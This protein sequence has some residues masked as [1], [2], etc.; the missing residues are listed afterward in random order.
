MLPV[1]T[2]SGS[3]DVAGGVRPLDHVENIP[4]IDVVATRSGDS[5]MLTLLCVNRSL[6]SDIKTNFDLGQRRVAAPVHV[7]QIS[8]ASRYERNDEVEPEHI[9]PVPGTISIPKAGA[10]SI[11]LPHESVTVLRVK[12]R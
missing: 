8:A 6:R 11:T 5:G 10:L 7:E 3:Y 9:V 12:V 2:D 1:S 4:E